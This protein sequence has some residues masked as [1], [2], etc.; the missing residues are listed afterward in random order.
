MLIIPYLPFIPFSICISGLLCITLVMGRS[1]SLLETGLT[2]EGCVLAGMPVAVVHVLERSVMML[3]RGEDKRW[4]IF[5]IFG[6]IT[7][8]PVSREHH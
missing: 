2:D 7:T 8:P 6:C 3:R 4:T 1:L 5:S